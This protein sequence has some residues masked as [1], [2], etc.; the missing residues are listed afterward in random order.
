MRADANALTMDQLA[1]TNK[2]TLAHVLLDIEHADKAWRE[3]WDTPREAEMKDELDALECE[4]HEMLEE[5]RPDI[6][7]I[8]GITLE[9]L[10]DL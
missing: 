2:R 9:Q 4:K 8:A 3:S 7:R 6:E 5:M 10:R 1:W